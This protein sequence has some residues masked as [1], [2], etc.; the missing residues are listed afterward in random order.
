MLQEQTRVHQVELTLRHVIDRDVMLLHIQI[1][2]AKLAHKPRIDVSRQHA[3]LIAN[4]L[5]EPFGDRSSPCPGLETRP[6]WRYANSFELRSCPGIEPCGT[7]RDPLPRLGQ[8]VVQEVRA[9]L[10]LLFGHYRCSFLWD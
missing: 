8:C 1:G 3:T 4:A 5:A 7:R 9:G 10:A 2:V 6:A